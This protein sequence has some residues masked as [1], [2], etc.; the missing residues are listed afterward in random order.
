MSPG[1][2]D[3]Q[4]LQSAIMEEARQ[5]A[6]QILADAQAQAES[7]HQ[8]AQTQADAEREAI[9]QQAREKTK[10]IHEH[11]VAAA[12][13]EAQKLKLERREQLLQQALASARQQLTSVSQRPDYEQIVK[14]LVREAAEHLGTDEALVRTDVETRKVLD[15]EALANLG[16]ELSVHLRAG[17]PLA[18]S[19]GIVLETP[20]G[21]RRYDNTLETRIARMWDRL[22]TPVY[23]ILTEETL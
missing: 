15:D 21:H 23:H 10:A 7:I 13:L 5:E 12:Q 18:Q 9:L 3:I 22:R 19:T 16:G 17:E 2:N 8:Q 14:R 11:T 1:Q 20:N 6:N 4:A